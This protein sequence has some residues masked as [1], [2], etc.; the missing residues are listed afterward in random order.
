MPLPL[1]EVLFKINDKISVLHD[2]N[3]ADIEIEV[4]YFT[5]VNL[6]ESDKK[7]LLTQLR[8]VR[9]E[10]LLNNIDVPIQVEIN[11]FDRVGN[12][13]RRNYYEACLE[14]NLTFN[15]NSSNIFT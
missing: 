5:M 10:K 11:Y 8:E 7:L 3:E 1:I 4:K 14:S 6:Y 12:I 13:S 15:I 2:C 9:L